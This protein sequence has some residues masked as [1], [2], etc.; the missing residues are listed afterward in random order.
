MKQATANRLNS[1]MDMNV[2]LTFDKGDKHGDT[3][4]VC[5]LRIPVSKNEIDAM[6]FLNKKF[7]KRVVNKCHQLNRSVGDLIKISTCSDWDVFEAITNLKALPEFGHDCKWYFGTGRKD[8]GIWEK[9][10]MSTHGFGMNADMSWINDDEIAML[11]MK[12]KV[13]AMLKQIQSNASS[14]DSKSL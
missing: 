12:A 2:I 1:F 13:E 6:T 10:L 9:I 3:Q 14:A 7:F 8:L 5:N 4:E 11:M